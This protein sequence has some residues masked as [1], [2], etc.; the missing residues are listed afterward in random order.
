MDALLDFAAQRAKAYLDSL[1][2]RPIAPAEAAV[3]ALSAFDHPLPK[4]PV[5]ALDTLKLL[6]ELGTPATMGIASGRF[7]GFVMGAPQPATLASHWLTAAWS[8]NTGLHSVTP[9]TAMLERVALG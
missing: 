9:M 3:A 8:Q 5:P 1:G 2:T 7:F 4:A 6:D